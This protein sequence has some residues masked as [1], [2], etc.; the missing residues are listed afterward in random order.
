LIAT[1]EPALHWELFGIFPEWITI[2]HGHLLNMTPP[3]EAFGVYTLDISASGA[4]YSAAAP[5]QI[6]VLKDGNYPPTWLVPGITAVRTS[7]MRTLDIAPLAVDL[8]ADRLRFSKISGPEWVEITSDGK[9]S[10]LAPEGESDNFTAWIAVS[11][12][13][14]R[15]LIEIRF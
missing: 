2:D 15:S 6:L 9:M 14:F 8:E 10:Y 4:F 3:S 1:T 5:V 13:H 12:D 11:D 7:E